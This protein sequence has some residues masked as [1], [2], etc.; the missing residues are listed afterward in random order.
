VAYYLAADVMIVTPLR[1]GMNLVAK[2]YC[3][4]RTDHSGVLIL[5]E[6]A[7]AARELRR[8]LQVN[9]RDIDAFKAVIMQALKLPAKDAR[10]RMAILRTQVRRH[11]V[12]EWS[13]KFLGAL[14]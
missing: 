4:C 12:Y 10:M 13:E 14:E 11:D 1:D 5:S 7:G 9:P 6:F 2:E 3:A 8:A